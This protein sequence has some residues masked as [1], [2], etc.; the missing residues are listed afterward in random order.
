MLK[1]NLTHSAKLNSIKELLTLLQIMTYVADGCQS[2]IPCTTCLIW[3]LLLALP[4][5]HTKAD[6]SRCGL[7]LSAPLPLPEYGM[8]VGI[9]MAGEEKRVT[10]RREDTC[11]SVGWDEA[12][13]C[14]AADQVGVH[15]L[16][17]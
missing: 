10:V 15:G 9:G 7:G 11:K 5:L 17:C 3:V 16:T 13:A 2:A 1:V 8:G 12:H 4:G 14:N 6:L